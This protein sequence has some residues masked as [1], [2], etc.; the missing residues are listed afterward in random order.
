M[1]FE[2]PLAPPPTRGSLFT[3]S[4]PLRA[5]D[6]AP[7]NRLRLDGIAR[8]LQDIGSDNADAAGFAET[9]PVWILRRT[10]IDVHTPAEW[11][12]RVSMRRWC[13]AY[14]TRWSTMRVEMTSDK[15]ARIETE[16]FWIHINRDTGMPSRIS[17]STLEL[18]GSHTDVDRLRWKPWLAEQLPEDGTDVPF[19]LRS[20]DFDPL[21]HVN[22]AAYLHAVEEH[23][24]TR[25]DLLQ[26]PHRVVIEYASPIT[27][28][29][30]L[31]IRRREDSDALSLWFVVNGVSRAGARLTRLT[32]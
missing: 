7:D 32:V 14:S 1:S 4:R 2:D 12:D 8:Y 17:D 16:G 28:G 24:I 5:G 19:P 10:V 23:A 30:Q 11:P 22:N 9:D 31:T 18:L 6:V 29:E 20:T 13:S 26:V 21:E 25:P 3:R 27:T 15:G